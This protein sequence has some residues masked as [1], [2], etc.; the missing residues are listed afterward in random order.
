MKKRT[1]IFLDEALLRALKRLAARRDVSFARV[2][3]E[4]AAA[5]V[6]APAAAGRLPSIAGRFASGLA[7][8][9]ARVDELLWTNP[10]T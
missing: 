5:Y 9:S 3:S 10:H 2:V 6:A 8:T 7:D 4:A 1:T